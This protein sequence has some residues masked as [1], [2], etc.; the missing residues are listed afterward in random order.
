MSTTVTIGGG[1]SDTFLVQNHLHQGCTL[2]PT[3]YFGLIIHRWFSR[4]QAAGMKVQF[5]LGGKFVGERT[6]RQSSFVVSGCLLQ[7]ILLWCA[8]VERIWS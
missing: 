3:L 2:A 5:M 6:R 4:C 7:M 8:Q 1:K